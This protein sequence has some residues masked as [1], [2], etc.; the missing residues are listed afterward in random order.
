MK[1]YFTGKPSCAFR[2]LSGILIMALCVIGIYLY[3]MP[4]AYYLAE[5]SILALVFCVEILLLV[6]CFVIF[7]V[8]VLSCIL[9]SES[10]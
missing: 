2:I 10:K 1:E 5:N 6:W 4:A 9:A 7:A 8:D 3:A